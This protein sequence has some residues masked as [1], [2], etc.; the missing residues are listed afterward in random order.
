MNG[1]FKTQQVVVEEE[2]AASQDLWKH[3]EL[4]VKNSVQLMHPSLDLHV[5]NAGCGELRLGTSFN[6]L[7]V[8][9]LI[10]E[11]SGLNC[12]WSGLICEWSRQTCEWSYL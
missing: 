8:S 1:V 11:W 3:P 10:Y 4:P 12:E 9:G 5:Y 2:D 6:H 7:I